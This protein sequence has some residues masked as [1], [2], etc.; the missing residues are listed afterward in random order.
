MHSQKT[1]DEGKS[2]KGIVLSGRTERTMQTNPVTRQDSAADSGY[3]T[4]SKMVELLV[5]SN[6]RSHFA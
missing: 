6:R 3:S 2:H 1:L 4:Y 5:P